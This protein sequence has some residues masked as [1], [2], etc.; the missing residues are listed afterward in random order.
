[1]ADR[2]MTSLIADETLNLLRLETK[3][4]KA[5][6]ARLACCLSLALDGREVLPSLNFGGGEIRQ[7]SF[8]GPDGPVIRTL[9][10]HVYE[11]PELP[12]RHYSPTVP[13]SKTTSIR[14][15]LTW[16]AGLTNADVMSV[17]G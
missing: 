2:L 17:C 6:L 7:S 15:A 9:I 14:V 12:T 1:M 13:S 10:A 4:D 5:M 11:Q 3:F 8:F 16:N